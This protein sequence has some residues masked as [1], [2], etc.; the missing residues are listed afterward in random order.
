MMVA[1]L[2]VYLTS[3]NCRLS[4]MSSLVGNF[5]AFSGKTQINILPLFNLFYYFLVLG[6]P[7]VKRFTLCNRTVV[8][9]VM[10]VSIGCLSVMLVYCRHMV[11]WIK[12]PL[13]M[14]VAS[15][16]TTL[17]YM[18]TQLPLPQKG[19]SSPHPIFDP[20]LLWSNGWMDQDVTW[21]GGR[22]CPWPHCVRWDPALLQKAHS[23]PQ[24]SAHVCC[25]QMAGW[26]RC[27]LAR[28]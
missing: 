14:E 28:R 19:N 18:G 10:A 25:G 6:W 1:W 3:E 7:F 24:F 21:Y 17:C 20:C 8:L 22:P 23:P 9:S 16:Q 2:H 11:G 15:T 4:T 26:T 12:V 5:L 27:H 13:G